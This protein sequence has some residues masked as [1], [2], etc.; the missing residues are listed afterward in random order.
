MLRPLSWTWKESVGVTKEAAARVEGLQTAGLMVYSYKAMVIRV[1]TLTSMM[2]INPLRKS[3]TVP[4]SLLVREY[5]TKA[6]IVSMQKRVKCS[7]SILPML[8]FITS[9]QVRVLL[10]G[11]SGG[12][13]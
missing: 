4:P 11:N 3:L 13:T 8:S 7:P 5:T 12:E 2:T 6:S 9:L 10:L 1:I